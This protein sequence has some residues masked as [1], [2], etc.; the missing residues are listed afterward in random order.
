MM[1]GSS[2]TQHSDLPG[3]Q[4]RADRPIEQEAVRTT[5]VGGRPPGS[6]QPLGAIPRG[7]EVLIKKAAVDAEFRRRLLTGRAAAAAEIGLALDPAEAM[8]LAAAP[9]E[10][11]EAIIARTSVPQ[12]HRRAFLGQAAA[13]M[14]AALGIVTATG[15]EPQTKGIRPDRPVDR[16]AR[17]DQPPNSTERMAASKGERPD[18]PPPPKP[19]EAPPPKGSGERTD[20]SLGTRPAVPPPKPPQAPPPEPAAMGGE[21]AD[22]PPPKTPEDPPPGPGPVGGS[23]PD[24][25]PKL[26]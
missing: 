26:E 25:P 13:A 1:E 11:I 16:G 21:R 7:L 22:V 14:A 23:R 20:V 8:M 10:Q 24:L 5:I 2:M 9:A 15:C 3:P 4:F 6:G 19:P 12:E 18:I 17:P